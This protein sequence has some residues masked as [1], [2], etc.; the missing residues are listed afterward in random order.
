MPRLE[1]SYLLVDI[2]AFGGGR[3]ADSDERAARIECRQR[4]VRKSLARSE[5]VAVSEDRAQCLW[6]RTRCALAAD[7]VLVYVKAFKRP[8]QPLA[9][10]VSAWLYEMKARYL[11]ATGSAMGDPTKIGAHYRRC[12]AG[13]QLTVQQHSPSR[14]RQAP[15]HERWLA[16]P[17]PMWWLH[18]ARKLGVSALWRPISFGTYANSI[19][20]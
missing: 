4:L 1:E 19:G 6:D 16:G 5:F 20:T 13:L 18:Q 17:I 15:H 2:R 10:F 11:S 14:R 3:R 8:M 9:Q 7:Q 12:T